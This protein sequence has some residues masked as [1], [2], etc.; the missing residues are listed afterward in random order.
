MKQSTKNE[1]IKE[2]EKRK[3]T[4][5][6][7]QRSDFKNHLNED[8]YLMPLVAAGSLFYEGQ[9]WEMLY[10]QVGCVLLVCES[11]Y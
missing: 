8:K 9:W 5:L 6:K 11:G 4:K 3:T 10:H 1:K 2:R 7:R